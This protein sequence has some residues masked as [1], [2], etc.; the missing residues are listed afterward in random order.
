MTLKKAYP[1]TVAALL[2]AFGCWRWHPPTLAVA[3]LVF[4]CWGLVTGWHVYRVCRQFVVGLDYL[5]LSLV[6]FVVAIGVSLAKSG[7]LSRWL[8]ALREED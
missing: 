8:A 3:G 6:I 2:V 7:I 4:V 1:P 5:A